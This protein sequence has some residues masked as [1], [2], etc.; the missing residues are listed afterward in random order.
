MTDTQVAELP[1]GALLRDAS[2]EFFLVLFV[3]F[4]Q[5]VPR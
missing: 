5:R 4:L 1:L 2:G 3:R